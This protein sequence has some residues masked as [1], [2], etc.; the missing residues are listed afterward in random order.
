MELAASLTLGRAV[1][2]GAIFFAVA[3]LVV[4]IGLVFASRTAIRRRLAADD[5]ASVIDLAPSLRPDKV[6]GGWARAIE[7]LEKR[8]VSLVDSNAAIGEKLAA[9]G[10]ASP[11]AQRVF[12]LIRLTLTLGLPALFLLFSLSLPKPPSM[13]ALYAITCFLALI[14]LYG[15]NLYISARAERRR[16]AIT[17][18]FPD[19]LDLML[20]C[21]EAG[22]SA[23]AA[24]N[25]VGA[26]V[27]LSQPL[28]AE[29]LATLSLELR[30]GRGKEDALRR[31]ADRAGVSE[32][33]SFATL[34]IQSDRLG[35]SIA[36]TLRIFSAEMRE[37]RRLRAE[38]KA[39]RLP[40]LLSIPL[41][42]CM[43]PTMIGVLMLPAGIRVV[44]QLFPA[45][46]GG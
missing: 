14:G 5:A 6:E 23:E 28:L 44:R 20:I 15:P 33:R 37:K 26:E 16:S 11:I 38:E 29:L 31:F 18:G 36:Q 25:R 8:G 1:I 7:S 10:Y 24:F 40:V 12:T 4:I 3:S 27:R 21:V 2:L 34:L 43:L 22:L 35:S 41:V 13:V 32:I 30:A 9:A 45:M 39:H 42:T 17:N 46:T 19:I